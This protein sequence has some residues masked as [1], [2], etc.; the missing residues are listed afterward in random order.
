VSGRA[1]GVFNFH[2]STFN[3]PLKNAKQIEKNIKKYE[4]KKPE[5]NT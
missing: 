5:E 1:G 2:S 3:T 4:K